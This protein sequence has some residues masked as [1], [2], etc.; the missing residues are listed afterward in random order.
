MSGENMVKRYSTCKIL[1][2]GCMA[3]EDMEVIEI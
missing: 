2:K 1:K 3:L